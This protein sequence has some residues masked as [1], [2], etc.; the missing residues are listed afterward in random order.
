MIRIEALTELHL[1]ALM[2]QRGLTVLEWWRSLS[3]TIFFF[4]NKWFLTT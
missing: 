4:M 2:F 1:N 3:V